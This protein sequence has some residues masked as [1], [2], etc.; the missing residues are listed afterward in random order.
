MATNA[1]V[2]AIKKQLNDSVGGRVVVV[3]VWEEG[4]NKSNR[5]GI[6]RTVVAAL[7]VALL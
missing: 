1:T 3:G 4:G 5:S 7:V 2:V 6:E